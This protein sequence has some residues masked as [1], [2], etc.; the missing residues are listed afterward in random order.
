MSRTDVHRPWNVQVAD[1]YNR[2]YR[3]YCSWVDPVP[4][5]T[6]ATC[7]CYLCKGDRRGDRRRGRHT[8]KRRLRTGYE[9]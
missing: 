4:Y 2:P 9:F 3:I 6:F 5:F 1:P 7:G 8:T